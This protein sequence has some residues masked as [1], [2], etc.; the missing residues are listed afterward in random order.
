MCVLYAVTYQDLHEVAL[1][2]RSYQISTYKDE[3]G[4]HS[5]GLANDGSHET[6]LKSCAQSQREINPWWAV[7]LEVQTLV[8]RVDLTNRDEY[9]NDV[10]F[11]PVCLQHR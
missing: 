5:A 2:K 3:Y 10:D 1:N 4:L 7:D 11:T 6:T 9:G 8:A